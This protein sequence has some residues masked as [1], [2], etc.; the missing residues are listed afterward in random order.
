MHCRDLLRQRQLRARV[1]D[2]EVA[3]NR[4]RPLEL[5]LQLHA[6]RCSERLQ[7]W[8]Q[9]PQVDL[10]QLRLN[11]LYRAVDDLIRHDHPDSL[12]EWALPPQPEV[13]QQA[14]RHLRN[15]QLVTVDVEGA[16]L[17]NRD[18]HQQLHWR[19]CL[20]HDQVRQKATNCR[21]QRP[22]DLREEPAEPPRS[23]DLADDIVD[24]QVGDL[25]DIRHLNDDA[26]WP[27][28]ALLRQHVGCVRASVHERCRPLHPRHR[29]AIP[30]VHRRREV[31]AHYSHALQGACKAP[32]E[33]AQHASGQAEGPP[34]KA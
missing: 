34:T 27:F 29:G 24:D 17:R 31:P 33:A 1:L 12:D 26:D 16:C 6:D 18:G 28:R 3:L 21:R 10:R 5:E 4:A 23:E 20:G 30:S 2:D 19:P 25:G 9:S 14:E 32:G 13:E 7:L 22:Q 15:R 8:N 11:S